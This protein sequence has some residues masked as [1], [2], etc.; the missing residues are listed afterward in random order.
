MNSQSDWKLSLAALGIVFGDIGTSPIYALRECL[1]GSHGVAP[2]EANILG[3]LSLI[4]W[5]LILVISVKYLI[6]VMRADNK[7]EGGI[8]ALVALLNPWRTARGSSRYILMLM[9]LFG[10][11]LLYGDGTITP[12]IS[13]LSAIEGLNVATPEFQDYVIPITLAILM[14]LFWIQKRGTGKIG[15]IFGPVIAVWFMAIA[16]LGVYGIAREPRVLFAMN[17]LYGINFLIDQGKVGFMVLGAVFLVATGGEALYADMGHFGRRPIR[18]AWF[19]L[20]LPSLLLNYFGQGALYL[21]GPKGETDPFYHL[22]PAWALYPLIGL[23]TLATIIASQAVISGAFSLTRQL[24]QL[25]Q[26]PRVSIIQTSF[27]EQGQIY[28]PFVNWM[29]M[30]ATILLVLGFKTSGALASAYG[31]AVSTTMVITSILAFFVARRFGWSAFS[32]SVVI[33]PLLIIDIVFFSANLFKIADGGWYPIVTAIF[34]FV[35][36]TTWSRGRQLLLKRWGKDAHS[37]DELLRYI[38]TEKIYR[39]PGTAV[40]FTPTGQVPPHM[41]RHIQRHHV[42][43]K[44]VLLLSVVTVDEPHVS[45]TQ[46]LQII[47]ID[48]T[49][50]RVVVRYGFMEHPDIPLALKLCEELGLEVDLRQMSYYVGRETVIPSREVEGMMLWRE[51]LFA[52]LSRNALRATAFYKLPADDVIELGFQIVI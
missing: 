29:L 36:I 2:N 12:A 9:G 38:K 44:N 23:A 51:Y 15:I 48:R 33:V 1:S 35:I 34:V 7:G 31:I 6:F 28:I 13:V 10:A 25:G 24:V 21:V 8:A 17:P 46:R 39:I 3:L 30:L 14:A 16:A 27:N 4:V 42:L 19:V 26:F 50:T 47:G 18:L 37:T 41:L 22:A 5:S 20:V 49:I 40:F 32:A 45:E 52:F 11:A 43:Q